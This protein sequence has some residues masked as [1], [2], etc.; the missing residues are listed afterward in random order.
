LR[1]PS[2][3]NIKLKPDEI[4]FITVAGQYRILTDFPFNQNGTVN[5][6][7]E[8][9]KSKKENLQKQSIYDLKIKKLTNILSL[10]A[11]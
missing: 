11:Q 4:L 3:K 1:A 5:S 10:L 8:L 6:L 2:G 7:K 9:Y